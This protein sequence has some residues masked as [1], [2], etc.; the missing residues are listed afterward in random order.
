[1]ESGVSK[2]EAAIIPVEKGHL[3]IPRQ[4]SSYPDRLDELGLSAVAEVMALRMLK[5]VRRD[6]DAVY[7]A[8]Q[9]ELADLVRVTKK[10][11]AR[12]VDEL[13]AAR[14]VAVQRRPGGRSRYFFRPVDEWEAGSSELSAGENSDNQSA[15][16]N[17]QSEIE[18]SGVKIPPNRGKNSPGVKIPPGENLPQTGVKIPP[19]RGK[20]SPAAL[21]STRARHSSTATEYNT[22]PTPQGGEVSFAP[23]NGEEGEREEVTGKEKKEEVVGS[24]E[25]VAGGECEDQSAECVEKSEIRNPQSEID[26][27]IDQVDMA[28]REVRGHGMPSGWHRKIRRECKNGDPAIFRR[29]DA[30]MIKKGFAL[31]GSKKGAWGI[32]WV[33]NAAELDAARNPVAQKTIPPND[34]TP[35]DE[36]KR[37]HD[38]TRARLRLCWFRKQP[39]TVRAEYIQASSGGVIKRADVIEGVAALAAWRDRQTER[40]T[41]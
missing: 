32:G 33:I 4:F 28:Y 38:E 9:N 35:D 20:N 16:Q 34:N 12:A 31:C 19:S 11:A 40:S 17:P 29:I 1:M 18:P 6:E 22:P 10:T 37:R 41:G 3:L 27:I 26:A 14:V 15:I 8:S 24:R 23:A 2:N 5:V 21:Y 7:V 30:R 25:P 39:E 13:L 36:H